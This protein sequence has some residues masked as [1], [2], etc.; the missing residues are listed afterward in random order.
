MPAILTSSKTDYFSRSGRI[1][2]GTISPALA[3]DARVWPVRCRTSFAKCFAVI[4]M[5]ALRSR[6]SR[7]RPPHSFRLVPCEDFV[8]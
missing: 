4:I 1:I 3:F 7:L 5:N 8:Y 6:L 2:L